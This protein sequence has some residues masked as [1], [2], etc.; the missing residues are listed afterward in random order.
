MDSPS[1]E[2]TDNALYQGIT[3][4]DFAPFEPEDPHCGERRAY[5]PPVSAPSSRREWAEH[6]WLDAGDSRASSPSIPESIASQPLPAYQHMPPMSPAESQGS[7]H[8]DRPANCPE[9][10]GPAPPYPAPSPA[11]SNMTRKGKEVAFPFSRFGRA[12]DETPTKTREERRS[13]FAH[14]RSAL[15][16]QSE[17][18]IWPLTCEGPRDHHRSTAEPSSNYVLQPTVYKPDEPVQ[19]AKSALK[20]PMN[21]HNGEQPELRSVRS[22]KFDLGPEKEVTQ[23]KVVMP[24]KSLTR[25]LSPMEAKK[26]TVTGLGL[27]LGEHLASYDKKDFELSSREPK[28]YSPGL[29]QIPSRE[30]LHATAS[31]NRN[32]GLSAIQGSDQSSNS[33]SY[34]E[35]ES[36]PPLPSS[37][38]QHVPTTPT[39]PSLCL[40]KS[41][42]Q[43]SS[44]RPSPLGAE[45]DSLP[46]IS[47]S[48]QGSVPKPLRI[49]SRD[50]D[51]ST[52]AA[53]AEIFPSSV[54]AEPPS[55]PRSF[56]P[57]SSRTVGHNCKHKHES[58]KWIKSG[59]MLP[60]L[61]Y[62]LVSYSI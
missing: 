42:S 43:P 30:S 7:R 51:S 5:I 58:G 37:L 16:S 14:P 31:A 38:N 2:D 47:P 27:C 61:A 45:F 1:A 34:L 21:S 60:S 52:A 24:M 9:A 50:S 41:Y 18:S 15:H 36:S 11:S 13:A 56:S 17:R 33:N 3:V 29:L 49:A 10:P 48:K 4:R 26:K 23:K 22:V 8:F 12:E 44:S 25:L 59:R 40:P 39:S 35:P 46:P 19:P 62:C 28:Q 32:T 20:S 6:S 54:Q 55:P 53:N 57:C